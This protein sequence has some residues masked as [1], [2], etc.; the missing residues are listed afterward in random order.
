MTEYSS[1]AIGVGSNLSDPEF[2]VRHAIS[3][4][5]TLSEQRPLVSSL[6]VTKAW[7]NTEQPD[8]INAVVMITTCLCPSSLLHRLQ[9]IESESGRVRGEHWGPRVLDLDILLFDDETIK[10]QDLQ[11]PHKFLHERRFV[12]Q[13][14][15]EICPDIVIADKGRLAEL[16]TQNMDPDLEKI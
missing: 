6:Y 4:L 12:M 2:Q 13:P 15:Y 8:F 1:A 14:L 11:I 9:K 10:T 7:G 5:T 16:L 3:E